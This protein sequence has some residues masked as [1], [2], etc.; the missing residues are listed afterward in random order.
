MTQNNYKKNISKTKNKFKFFE[1]F[2]LV[3]NLKNFKKQKISLVITN[4]KNDKLF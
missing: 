3:T 4:I 2:E 1:Y